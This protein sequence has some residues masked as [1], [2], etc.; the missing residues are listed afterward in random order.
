LSITA[1]CIGII[2][3]IAKTSTTIRGFVRDVREARNDLGATA[4]LLTELDITINLI[5]DDHG[6]GDGGSEPQIPESI[7]VQTTTVIKSCNDILAELDTIIDKHN[8]R[9]HR[10][11]LRW[12]LKGKDDVSALNRQL[13]AHTRTL[14]MAL[15]ISTL[16]VTRDMLH[17]YLALFWSTR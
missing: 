9:R 1:G 8:P 11:P 4:R 3:A 14:T 5:K 16:F 15:E 17:N 6:E 2:G 13:E 12:V 10:T 7:T